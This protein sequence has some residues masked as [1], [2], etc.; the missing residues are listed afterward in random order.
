MAGY[1]KRFSELGKAF[2][3]N[4]NVAADPLVAPISS[5]SSM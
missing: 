3:S 2:P 4:I 5:T 1:A